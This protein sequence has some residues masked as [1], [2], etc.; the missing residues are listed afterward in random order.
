ML[1]AGE[2]TL[3]HRK[4][5]MYPKGK[6]QADVEAAH[7]AVFENLCEHVNTSIISEGN[8]ERMSTLRER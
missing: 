6:N 5:M 8:M 1:P 4:C 3:V 2:T 7:K